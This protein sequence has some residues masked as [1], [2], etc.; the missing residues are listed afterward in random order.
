MEDESVSEN[1]PRKFKITWKRIFLVAFGMCVAFV[2][3]LALNLWWPF[4]IPIKISKETTYIT[5][6]LDKDGLPDY[7]QAL[8]DLIKPKGVTPENNGA[9]LIWK[10]LGPGE[11]SDAWNENFSKEIGVSPLPK[12][13][14]YLIG[15]RKFTEIKNTER[16]VS[17]SDDEVEDETDFSQSIIDEF[18]N[19][20]NKPWKANDYPV[21]AEWLKRNEKPIQLVLQAAERSHYYEPIVSS[22]RPGEDQGL[23]L[24]SSLPII[25][26][27]RDLSQLLKARAMQHLG[28]GDI[29]AARRH[30]LAIH[31]LAR[32]STKNPMLIGQLVGIAID[33]RAHDGDQQLA[34]H[35]NLS[36]Q[37]LLEYRRQLESLPPICDISNIADTCERFLTLDAV[38]QL[39]WGDARKDPDHIGYLFSSIPLHSGLDAVLLSTSFDWN[40]ILQLVNEYTDESVNASRLP[41]LR[42]KKAFQEIEVR[43]EKECTSAISPTGIASVFLMS[44]GQRGRWMG[45]LFLRN[46]YPSYGRCMMEQ[47]RSN[48]K[49]AMTQLTFSL[50]AC[51]KDNGRYPAKLSD[52]VPKY[53]NKI[54]DD[55]FSGKPLIYKSDG[56]SFTLY[57]V[58]MN[59]IDDGGNGYEDDDHQTDDIVVKSPGWED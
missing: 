16:V 32:F 59:G 38:T 14:D 10:A 36:S 23:L 42:R 25:Q 1:K 29:S 54:P 50:E 35:G 4:A 3:M 8:N 21:Y 13:G 53:A 44:P 19:V 20:E 52:L 34:L 47:D 58:G 28:E 33:S 6:P 24:S 56:Q 27:Q 12:V 17:S 2:L 37:E 48:T 5:A 22:A 26:G 51:H 9:V 57:C 39:G 45:L 55:V 7:R 31:K 11:A 15:L 46:M 30:L 40:Q 43:L 49:R 41:H 18:E